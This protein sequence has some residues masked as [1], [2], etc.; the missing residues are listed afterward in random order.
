MVFIAA[1][2]GGGTGTGAAPVIA[3]VAKEIGALTIGVVT[4]PF[5]FEG[6][7]RGQSAEAGIDTLKEK[8]DTLIVIPNDRLLQLADKRASLQQAFRLADDVLH[9]GSQGIS[10][11]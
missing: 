1:G 9:P 10:G 6:A 3:Q 4:R 8:V 11:V 2:I 5:T 7:K